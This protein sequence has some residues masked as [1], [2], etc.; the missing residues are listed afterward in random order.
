MAAAEVK[1]HQTY[2]L[3]AEQHARLERLSKITR[4]PAAVFVREGIDMVI[5]HYERQIAMAAGRAP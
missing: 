5:D 4:V 3:D 2:S 1:H